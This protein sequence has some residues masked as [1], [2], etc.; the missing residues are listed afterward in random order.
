[1]PFEQD[2]AIADS[3]PVL[4]IKDEDCSG[5]EPHGENQVNVDTDDVTEVNHGNDSQKATNGQ[6]SGIVD[7]TPTSQSK[8]QDYSDESDGRHECSDGHDVNCHEDD[9]SKV[10][11][12]QNSINFLSNS[13]DNG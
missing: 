3:I 12:F 1:M 8:C 9:S 5:D 7:P 2:S 13:K 4:Q 11:I 10:I 6:D